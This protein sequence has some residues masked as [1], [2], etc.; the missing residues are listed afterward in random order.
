MS[1][2]SSWYAPATDAKSRDLPSSLPADAPTTA[3]RSS[4]K[5]DLRATLTLNPWDDEASPPSSPSA[6]PPSEMKATQERAAAGR[7]GNGDADEE[8]DDEEE[9][10][11]TFLLAAAP[12]L[13]RAAIVA[14]M[15]APAR[16]APT[17][18]IAIDLLSEVM[19]P[20]SSLY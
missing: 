8:E 9:A 14:P 6:P 16:A 5:E 17:A 10:A 4:K 11:A 20:R 2:V 13:A 3:S 1:G 19:V 12:D 15:A 7:S 18:T